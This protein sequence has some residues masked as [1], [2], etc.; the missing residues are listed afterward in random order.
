M[1]DVTVEF[2]ATDTGLEKTLKAVQ[3]ELTQLKG[4]VSSGELSMTELESTM[5]RIGQVTSMEK[6][7]KA[8]GGQSQATSGDVSKMGASMEETGKKGE[9]GFGKIVSASAIAGAAVKAGMAAVD[10]A[11]A[12]ISGSFNMLGDAI[13]KAANFQQLE[14]SFNVLIGNT[15]LAKTFLQDL[16][17]FADKTPFTITGLAEASK[18]LISFGMV[19][20]EVLPAIS[21]LGDVAQGNE[22]NLKLLAEAFGKVNSSGRLTGEELRSMVHN[23]FN[24]LEDISQ[25][26][27]KSMGELRK[28]ME[29]GNITSAMVAEAFK[30]STSEGGRFFDMTKKQSL[31]FN[32]VMSTMQDTV[33][34]LYRRF[35]RP[36]IDALTPIIQQW[37]ERIS[38]IAPLFD[39]IGKAAGNTITFFSDLINKTLN[40]EQ[41]IGNIGTSLKAISGGE[42]ALG[43]KNIFLSMKVWA[44]ESANEIYKHLG[45]AFKTAAE[46]AGSIFAPSG[47]LSQ[48]ILMSFDVI[49]NKAGASIMT[50]LAQA[51]DGSYLTRG[52]ANSLREMAAK[53]TETAQIAEEGLKGAG[54]RIAEQFTTAGAALPK[55]FAENYAAIPPLFDD[56]TSTQDQIDANNATIAASTK[57]IVSTDEEAV[58]EAKAYFDQWKKSEDLKK[59]ATEKAAETLKIEQDKITAKQN[60]L[61]FQLEL[62]QAQADGN[63]AE[64]KALEE[65]KVWLDAWK[66][67]TASGMG[68]ANANAFADAM[69][70]AKQITDSMTGKNIII[71]VTTTVDDTRWKT[72]LAEI[73][74]E[75]ATQHSIDVA[76]KLTGQSD[77]V[78][79]RTILGLMESKNIQVGMKTSGVDSI[80][81]LQN[82]LYSLPTQKDVDL[83]IKLTGKDD[84][85]S[86][87]DEVRNLAPTKEVLLTLKEQGFA[88]LKEYKDSIASIGN[89]AKAEIVAKDM[90]GSLANVQSA[91]YAIIEA[92]KK[93]TEVS[94]KATADTKDAQDKVKSL[95]DI[96][97]KV[98]A[99]VDKKAFD[100]SIGNLNA[101]IKNNFTGGVGGVGGAGGNSQGGA[102]G[103]AG[104]GGDGGT[105]GDATVPA[106]MEDVMSAIKG[107]VE[108]IKDKVVNLEGKLPQP[109]LA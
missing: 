4:K 9:I 3:D 108:T 89:G 66:Q 98:T 13:N 81:N 77:L 49:A 60:E 88:S 100:N 19:S 63:K 51:F 103:D 70:R 48:T 72:L 32:G 67:A 16:V 44:M 61:K 8:I 92:G 58:A 43:I 6:N 7:I 105:G 47:A 94:V 23:G 76:L 29:K 39:I 80:E 74:S 101:E 18:T 104:S 26:T 38:N 14:T 93:P 79:A 41:A 28:E 102:G 1:A 45:A 25:K 99:T 68:E 12:A 96:P 35:G 22:E 52:I 95:G 40:V 55:S 15:T 91:V 17:S 57:E 53:A 31:T 2:G 20:S 106:T 34:G 85:K 24:P 90:G 37:S 97:V 109:V 5:K 59:Q 65:R 87:A 21:M 84:W 11:F 64:I 30:S 42:Y 54:G 107:F 82:V 36:I 69:L 75:T 86:A 27:G 33:D 56:I 73:N 71:T 78:G 50:A 46:F 62:A 10:A 83:A